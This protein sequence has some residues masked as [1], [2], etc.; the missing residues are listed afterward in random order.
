MNL[1]QEQALAATIGWEQDVGAAIHGEVEVFYKQLDNLIV[2]NPDFGG[3]DDTFFVNAGIGRAYG[4][5]V[6]LRHDPV[7]RLFGWISYTLSRSERQDG[8]DEDWYLFDYDQTHI[9]S[10]VAG[11]KLPYDFEISA[12]GQYVTGNPTTPYAFG[13]YDIDQDYY[14]G[15]STGAY[16]SERL[17]AYS[18]LSLR[19]DKLFTFKGFQLDLY[20]DLINVLHGENPE[21]EVYN[22]DY[23]EK[24]YITGI[25]FIP[26]PGFDLKYEF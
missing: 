3:I 16:N 12:K 17:P 11:Y 9:L 13:V 26:G 18:A 15:F 19:F 25:P 2:G 7:G 8:P 21:F 20:V 22:Y 23:T 14:E 24:R 4:L 6:I 5:E 10:A 1:Q